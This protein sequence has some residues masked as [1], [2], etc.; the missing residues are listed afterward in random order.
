MKRIAKEDF[1]QEE[2]NMSRSSVVSTSS[3]L[4]NFLTFVVILAAVALLLLAGSGLAQDDGRT[5]PTEEVPEVQAGSAP[6]EAAAFKPE[7]KV[8]TPDSSVAHPEDAGVRFHTNYLIFV[9]EGRQLFGPSPDFTFAETPASLGCVYKVGPI[10]PGCNPATGGT[11][12]PT[13]GWGAIALVD[14]FD[15]PNAASDLAVFSTHWGLPAADFTKVYANGNGSCSVPP[16]NTGWGVEEDLD[17]EWAHAMAPSAKIY[18]VEACSASYT[19]LFYAETVASQLVHAA[20]GGDISNSWSGGEFAGETATDA[21]FFGN[22]RDH[23]TYFASAGDTG[24]GAA[25]PSS[26]P[27]V[28]SAGGT[29]VN[30]DADGNFLNESCW[31]GSGGGISSQELWQNPPAVG[32]GMGPWT[33]FQFPLFGQTARQTP[34]LSFNADPTSGVYIYDSYGFGGWLVVGGTSLSSPSLAGIVN[35]SNNRLGLAAV[36]TDETAGTSEENNLLYAQLLN[37]NAYPANFYD[38]KTGSNG[39]PAGRGWDQ[40]TGVGTPRGKLGK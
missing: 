13:G 3:V 37:H 9:P 34:D 26:S 31:A 18:L 23:I 25:Y 22:N 21:L 30:R 4:V 17:I 28:V 10:Y 11:R 27:W 7:G 14:A 5:P 32:N 8:I 19:D 1:A 15:N 2:K 40:C 35:N 24:L 16:G 33:A 6:A 38:V 12:H 39:S 20:G 29:T 36:V